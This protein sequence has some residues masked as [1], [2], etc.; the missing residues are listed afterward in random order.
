[1]NAAEAENR[2]LVVVLA[3]I[4]SWSCMLAGS[5]QVSSVRTVPTCIGGVCLRKAT[6]E[7]IVSEFG[8]GYA[9]SSRPYQ[10]RCYRDPQADVFLSVVSSSFGSGEVEAVLL[11]DHT[12]SCRDSKEASVRLVGLS[13]PEGIRLGSERGEVV[14]ILGE[15]NQS[16]PGDQWDRLGLDGQL[17]DPMPFGDTILRYFS[18]E[19]PSSPSFVVFLLADRVSAILINGARE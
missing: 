6:M 4:V 18:E 9:V 13:T 17:K 19:D 8:I 10:F 15:P 5:S 3:G 12:P 16:S 1:M 2:I 7:S 14:R 11:T